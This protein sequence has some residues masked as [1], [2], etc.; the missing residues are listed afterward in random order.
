[1]T[2]TR[3]LI[4]YSKYGSRD[5]FSMVQIETITAC[6]RRCHYCPNS[7]FDRGLLKN[8]R[9][10]ETKIFHKIIDELAQLRGWGGD[11]QPHFYGE[12]LMDDRMIEFA[13][14]IRS[15]MPACSISIFTNGDFL[16][17][18]LYRKLISAGVSRFVITKHSAQK[19]ANI[20]DVLNYRMLYGDASVVMQYGE[21]GVI[22]NRGG[23]VNVENPVQQNKCTWVPT[24]VIVDYDGNVLPCCDDYLSTVKIGNIKTEPLMDIWRKRDYR[25]LRKDLRRGKFTLEL[26]KKCRNGSFRN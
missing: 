1:M 20:M 15:K 21:L 17:L 6:N 14:Y 25:K 22:S 8:N 18:E 7:Q 9:R 24:T 3:P 10:L 13:G 12:P 19:A 11:I 4:N 26:C 23:L 16:T 2:G 5:I